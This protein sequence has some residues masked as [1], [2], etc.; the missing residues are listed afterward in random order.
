M[1]APRLLL[2]DGHSLAFRSYYAF[3][4]GREGGLRTTTGI[5]TSVTYGFLKALLEVL[6]RQSFTHLAVAFDLGTPTFRHVADAR[7]KEGRAETPD[8]FHPDVENLQRL[9]R[10]LQIPVVMA[11]GYEADDVLGT[12]AKRA[13]Q[14]GFEVKILSGDQD[15][16]QLVN[17][18]IHVLHLSQQNGP[19]IEYDPDRVVEKLGIQPA[20]VIDYKALCGD[21]S[22]NIPGV[23][24]IG[25]KTA[26]SLLQKYRDLDDLYA[27]LDELPK[28]QQQKLIE[29]KDAAYHS[30]FMATI[31]QDVPLDI[32]WE[33]C[34]LVGF[35]ILEVMPLLEELEMQSFQR[36]IDQ[37]YRQ[38][39]GTQQEELDFFSAEETAQH[40]HQPWT[41]PF[42]VQ[43]IRS[44]T[45]LK[46]LV[47]TLHQ[48]TQTPVAWDTETTALDPRDA[49]L[50]GIGCCWAE[51][52]VAY[53]PVG[54]HQGEQLD[55]TL[56][57][58]H[59]K[60]ILESEVH[61]KVFQ[62]TKFDRNVLRVQGI[63]LRGVVFDTL[64]A[65]YVLD[66]EGNHKLADLGAKYLGL[67][68]QSYQD[69]VAKN[70]T[71]ADLPISTV[72]NYCGM[73][74]YLT[75]R[76]APILEQELK[77][78]PSLYRVFREIEL[79]LE[80]VLAAMEYQGIALDLQVLQQLSQEFDRQLQAVEKRAHELVGQE[81]NLNS[82][83]QLSTLLFETLGLN[84]KKAKK[85][86][87]GYATDAAT[88]EKLRD[89]HPVIDCI[90]EH[91]TLAKLKSTYV[92]AL[93]QLC[94]QDTGRVHTDFNQTITATGRLSSS[95]P[96]LQNIPVRTEIGR[97]IRRAFIPQPG[98]LLVS[99]DYS[100]IELRILAHLSQEPVLIAAFQRGED[101]HRLTAQLLLEKDEITPEDR[102]LA[103]IINYGIVYGMG[104]QRFMREAG[105]SFAE[106]K[107]FIERFNQRYP[108]VFDYLRN[109]EKQA[110]T[111]GYVE[112]ITGRRRYFRFTSPLLQ[113]LRGKTLTESDW[114]MVQKRINAVDAGLL[115]AAANAPIQ[116]S[117]ADIIK[118]AMIRIHELLQHYQAHLL[119]QV[120]DELVFEMPP[121]EWLQLQSQIRDIMA[122]AM[123][124]SV[125][126]EVDIHAGRNW[127]EAK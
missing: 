31:H 89:E 78:I 109:T 45:E 57:L 28:A 29:G 80:P 67:Y 99:A 111:Q 92:D 24:G 126:L 14:D 52:Q 75:F 25:A 113:Q 98:W 62:N 97:Q 3:A 124:L 115:R 79:P 116:G 107:E 36:Q 100:Q 1:N 84:K 2:V 21:S 110:I 77:Q 23:R 108:A 105:V 76:L 114:A 35:D 58:H 49:E 7:Y 30:R 68:A 70:Q 117:S 88:L 10:A 56:V 27:H 118:I 42:E 82:P 51:N 5:P 48:C 61:P 12:L 86:Q 41:P 91:R 127:Q 47:Q 104:P 66:P 39:G 101:I 43:I 87:A 26:V 44:E 119:L 54:H 11:P 95:N 59:L 112:T 33:D 17:D 38:L 32:T 4:K 74:V 9:L 50:V 122:Q 16:F 64:L 106:A 125:P 65:S 34:Q 93:A 120:H 121:D 40:Q 90:L 15:L 63:E 103:K 94:R 18:R 69:V 37:L 6:N 71:M 53:I 85:T 55:K 60:P 81:F 73:D 13:E 46:N 96:N 22:D 8:D 83:K 123:P 72:A 20:Q 102:R 19:P